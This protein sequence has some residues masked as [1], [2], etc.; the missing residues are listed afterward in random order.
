MSISLLCFYLRGRLCIYVSINC[1]ILW[2]PQYGAQYVCVPFDLFARQLLH[3]LVFQTVPQYTCAIHIF[4]L[5]S[6]SNLAVRQKDQQK[7]EGGGMWGGG[8]EGR[9]GSMLS[10][11]CQWDTKDFHFVMS[12]ALPFVNNT[13]HIVKTCIRRNFNLTLLPCTNLY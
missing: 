8:R 9:E 4:W 13:S 5:P 12:T 6:P 1:I 10:S 11:S 2:R 7:K 3:V